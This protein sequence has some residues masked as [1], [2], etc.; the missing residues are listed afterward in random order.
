MFRSQG[1]PGTVSEGV[2]KEPVSLFLFFF[3][4]HRFSL[5]KVKVSSST[6]CLVAGLILSVPASEM[7][8]LR[9][10]EFLLVVLHYFISMNDCYCP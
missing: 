9:M 1:R 8:G 7:K 6:C 10:M 2:V 3:F 5:H 4:L